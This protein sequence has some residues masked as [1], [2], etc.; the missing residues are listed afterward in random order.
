MGA[1]D[2]MDATSDGITEDYGGRITRE[3]QLMKKVNTKKPI[4]KSD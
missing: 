2:E 3:G 4:N 1:V